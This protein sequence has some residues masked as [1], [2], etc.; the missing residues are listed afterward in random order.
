MSKIRLAGIK[1]NDI[2]DGD[3]IC[4]SV[5]TQGCPHRCP[6][7]HNPETWEFNGG[8]EYNQEE[9]IKHIV[10]LIGKNGIFRGL[11]ILGGEPFCEENQ[12]FSIK[13]AAAAHEKY[14]HCCIYCWTGYT[15]EE[16]KKM[17]KLDVL[18]KDIDI[19]IDGRYIDSQRDITLKW[20]GSPNQ[21][22]RYKGLDY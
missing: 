10:D 3:G 11:S 21:Q 18:L 16:L 1:E 14:P 6:G 13:L 19:L 2:V 7:C 15:F 22:I 4:V 12:E 20:R 9:V 17:Y 8:E 5:W